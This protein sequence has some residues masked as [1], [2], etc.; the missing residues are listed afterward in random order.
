MGKL[1]HIALSVPDPWKTAEFYKHAFGLEVVG[2]TDSSLAEGV[3]L[4]DGVINVALLHFKSDE[5]AQGSGK[6]HV[7]LHHF[8]VWVDD[9]AE[10]RRQVEAAGGTW[11]MGEPEQKGGS[12]YEVKF[13]DPDGIVFDLS[14]NGW[15][16]A[17]KNPGA[18]GNEVGPSRPLVPKFA[19]RRQAA[20]QALAVRTGK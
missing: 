17:Q 12:F 15:G 14:E 4:S 9:I 20:A 7:G 10:A 6:D 16:G 18:A 8:G 1:R 13:R 3:F 2:E 11:L 5:A 19:G